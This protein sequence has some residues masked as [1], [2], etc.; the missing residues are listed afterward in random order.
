MIEAFVG[1]YLS[2]FEKWLKLHVPDNYYFTTADGIPK[3]SPSCTV[4][5]IL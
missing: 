4:L 5:S 1:K 3:S 2:L